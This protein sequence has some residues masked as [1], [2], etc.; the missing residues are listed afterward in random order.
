MGLFSFNTKKRLKTKVFCI[1]FHKTG[2]SSLG[3]ALEE[4]G[5]RVVG[6]S[7]VRDPDIKNN[8]HKMAADLIKKYDAFQANP[9]PII[10]KDL[11]Q[12]YPGSKFILTLRNSQ[13]WITSQVN[14]FGKRETPMREWI[15]GI[16]R[17]CPKGNEELY[18]KRFEK[19]NEEVFE[20]F[21]GRPQD[22]LI[23]DFA[24]GDGWE[25]LCSFLSKDIP[26]K[27][28]PHSNKASDRKRSSIRARFSALFR[29]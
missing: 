3:L 9:W 25:K 6:S 7:G 14:H 23:M 16:G 10:Y 8:V 13:S 17:S 20:Y 24:A 28:F 22:L 1:G 4:L 19:H 12:N 29:R 26:A 11:D 18:V 27:A 5:Y 15:Y 2:T 21:K